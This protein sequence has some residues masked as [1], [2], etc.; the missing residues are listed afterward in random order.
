MALNL[1]PG[2]V[3]A[4]GSLESGRILAGDVGSGKSIVSLAFYYSKIAGGPL[5]INDLGE[6]GPRTRD[7]PLYIITTAKKRDDREWD[8]ELVRFSLERTDTPDGITVDSWNNIVKY[9]DVQDAF[10]IFDEQ[11]LVGAGAWVK[12]FLRLAKRNRWVLLS[13]TPGDVWIDYCP[14]FIA[15]GF[16]KNRS[17]FTAQHCVYNSW[18]GYPKIER[19]VDVHILEQLRKRVLVEIPFDRHTTRHIRHITTDYDRERFDVLWHKRWNIFDDRPVEDVAE[20]FRLARMLVNSDSTRTTAIVKLLETH[21]RLIIFYNFNYELELL[22]GL[23]SELTS[24]V[25]IAEWNGHKHQPVPSTTSW[26]YLVQYTAGSEGWECTTTDAMVFYS[27][28]YSYRAW[29]QAMGRIDR[30]NTP[31]D[32]LYYY[33]LMSGA[34]IDKAIYKANRS[35]KTFNENTF[36]RSLST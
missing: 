27:L 16:Y 8:K 12:A 30:F 13:A 11:R 29:S 20:L 26:L 4:L 15:N 33:V 3:S 32:D 25:E 18:G 24:S 23:T 21:P 5:R 28:N 22:R 17:D 14:I 9:R 7:V 35:K 36:M 19:Y 2:Q 10:F 31:F 34:V 1:Y 6:N